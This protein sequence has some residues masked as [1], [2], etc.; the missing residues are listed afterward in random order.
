MKKEKIIYEE[1]E[2]GNIKESHLEE[3]MLKE[4]VWALYGIN[5]KTG[6]ERCLQVGKSKNVGNE[7]L[8][9]IACLHFLKLRTDGDNDYI[10]QFKEPCDFKYKSNQV[11]EYLYPYI[12]S[13]WHSIKFLYVW[14]NS[15][16][17]KE[18]EYAHKYSAMYWR[19]GRPYGVKKSNK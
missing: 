1:D 12:A 8:S 10:N 9:D 7:I 17:D 13:Q 2:N 14:D 15:D 3:F 16:K 11:R 4:G 19:N 6:N 5:S 18:K